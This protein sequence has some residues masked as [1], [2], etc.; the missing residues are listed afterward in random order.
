MK[1]LLIFLILFPLFLQ[2][3]SQS[4]VGVG[5][6]Q[7]ATKIPTQ[8]DMF[9]FTGATGYMGYV[10]DELIM[11]KLSYS[12][13]LDIAEMIETRGSFDTYRSYIGFDVF[14]QNYIGLYP[15]MMIAMSDLRVD[16]YEKSFSE[17]MIGLEFMVE[18]P[19]K[20]FGTLGISGSY[21]DSRLLNDEMPSYEILTT[22]YLKIFL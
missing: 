22:L 12:H 19:L 17:V 10:F 15:T 20:E 6:M 8:E 2:S 1:K 14:K 4:L 21:M 13:S 16:D 11:L 7:K 3:Y 5:V 9:I 18:R